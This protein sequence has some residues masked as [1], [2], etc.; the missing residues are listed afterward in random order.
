MNSRHILD[1][2]TIGQFVL[3]NVIVSWGKKQQQQYFE[4]VLDH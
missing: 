3:N 1:N 2:K 4:C